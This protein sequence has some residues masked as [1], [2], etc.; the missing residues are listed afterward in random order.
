M[1]RRGQ[2]RA[3]LAGPVVIKGHGAFLPAEAAGVLRRA[4]LR[5]EL[6]QKLL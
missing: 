3:V 1:A 5:V 2:D 4:G 6:A